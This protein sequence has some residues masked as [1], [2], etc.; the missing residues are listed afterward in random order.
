MSSKLATL[1]LCLAVTVC[2]M[3]TAVQPAASQTVITNGTVTLG[4]NPEGHLNVVTDPTKANQD[5]GWL[6]LQLN[7]TGLD[8]L[9]HLGPRE[10]WGV[11]IPG[12]AI[13]GL[14]NHEFSQPL[15]WTTDS[16]QII[17][18]VFTTASD[19]ATSVVRITDGFNPILE[20][21]HEWIPIT[22]DFFTPYLYQ[23]NVTIR[24]LTDTQVGTGAD[25]VRYRR[26]MD[27]DAEPT[28]AEEYVT[29]GGLKPSKPAFVRFTSDDGFETSMPGQFDDVWSSGFQP[30]GSPVDVFLDDQ[31]VFGAVN[32][33]PC[34]FTTDFTRCG[35]RGNLA[36]VADHG[37][38][39]DFAFPALA[40]AGTCTDPIGGPCDTRTFTIFY[41]AAPTRAAAEEALYAVGA[42]VYSLAN[43]QGDFPFPDSAHPVNG[44]CDPV[45]G[46]PTTFIFGA[47]GLSG[48]PAFGDVFGAA[49]VDRNGNGVF[50]PGV[51]T[52]MP[53]VPLTVTGT[54]LSGNPVTRSGTTDATGAFDITT[55]PRGSY[56]I[57]APTQVGTFTLSRVVGGATFDI[58]PDDFFP[59]RDFIY[60]NK[61][62]GCSANVSLASSFN[63]TPIPAGRS[64]WFNSVLKVTGLGSKPVTITFRNVTIKSPDGLIN[65]TLPD[66]TVTF[67][68]FTK[69]ATTSFTGGAWVTRV[70]LASSG[71]VFLSGGVLPVPTALPGGIKTVKWTGQILSDTP[72]VSIQWQW[73]AAVYTTLST[74]LDQ[75]GVKPVNDSKTSAYKNADHAGT[76]ESFKAFVVGGARGV[77]G[78]NFTGS[79][80]GTGSAGL[81]NTPGGPGNTPGGPGMCQ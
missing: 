14:V 22:P 58:T 28:F 38:L 73:A 32:P 6:G 35:Y 30:F 31:L 15:G 17:P 61:M 50:D 13:G 24:N 78:S 10:G 44:D 42:E 9:R 75:L 48:S 51:D 8:G 81:C 76:P 23:A 56:T 43:C 59:Q 16:F 36:F 34:G 12:T 74:N 53:N 37:A 60:A 5:A 3:V 1:V 45:A 19:R 49:F 67:S 79:Y 4:V 69:V 64:I 65:L 47:N 18:L 26:V 66:S 2:V 62:Q 25:G 55:L 54:D 29:I 57:S 77:G 39:F 21:T 27:W 72:G 7:A 63:G 33:Q 52:P 11:A 41:G 68:P 70:P 40:A 71:N 46:T 20:V 80:N